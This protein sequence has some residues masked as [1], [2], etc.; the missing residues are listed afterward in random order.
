[1]RPGNPFGRRLEES[2]PTEL[3]I[4]LKLEKSPQFGFLFGLFETQSSRFG[5]DFHFRNWWCGLENDSFLEALDQ[6]LA[7]LEELLKQTSQKPRLSLIVGGLPRSGTTFFTQ[8]LTRNSSIGAIDGISSRFWNRPLVGVRISHLTRR[9][10]SYPLPYISDLGESPFFRDPHEF[11]NFWRR[12]VPDGPTIN[13]DT[14]SQ[15]NR[16]SRLA[17]QALQEISSVAGKSMVYKPMEMM[18]SVFDDLSRADPQLLFIFLD[19]DVGQVISS[20]RQAFHIALNR[21]E[22]WWGSIIPSSLMKE[23]NSGNIDELIADQIIWLRESYV[24]FFSTLP[25]ENRMTIRYE[26]LVSSS[27]SC[28]EAV[29]ERCSK[30]GFEE[31]YA[32]GQDFPAPQQMHSRRPTAV[33]PYFIERGIRTRWTF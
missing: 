7:S 26:N 32:E 17:L 19:R 6:S 13:P 33:P 29:C 11:G 2:G 28:I 30:L 18:F 1:M 15:E 25:E 8:V 20:M 16:K 5:L 21:G 23:L 14:G 24:R 9:A 3:P 27:A 4:D 22:S 10:Q 31:Q 12:F